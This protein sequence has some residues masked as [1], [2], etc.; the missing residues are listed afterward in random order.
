MVP[1]KQ[2]PSMQ[3]TKEMKMIMSAEICPLPLSDAAVVA[4]DSVGFRVAREGATEGEGV[5]LLEGESVGAEGA[6]VGTK[7][8]LLVGVRDGEAVG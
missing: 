6:E 2:Q 7:V 3:D 8:G 4:T 5:G 1:M